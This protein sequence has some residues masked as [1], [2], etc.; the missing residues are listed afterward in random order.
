MI[1]WLQKFVELLLNLRNNLITHRKQHLVTHIN[2]NSKHVLSIF[3]TLYQNFQYDV[4]LEF[5]KIDNE[6]VNK[7]TE[8]G[9]KINT[10][11]F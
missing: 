7:Q 8:L 2:F 6:V 4:K 5:K 10:T 11:H 3:I 1:V 9:Y